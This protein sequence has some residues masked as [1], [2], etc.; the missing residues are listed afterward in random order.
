MANVFSILS[1]SSNIDRCIFLL[2]SFVYHTIFSSQ[3]ITCTITITTQINTMPGKNID[4]NKTECAKEPI[5]KALLKIMNDRL[6]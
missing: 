3:G 5:G 2:C 6:G 1:D 4:D